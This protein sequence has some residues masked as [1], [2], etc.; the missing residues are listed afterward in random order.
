MEC[1]EKFDIYYWCVIIG[2][3]FGNIYTFLSRKTV[4]N[5]LFEKKIKKNQ[6]DVD[7]SNW[8]W[9]ITNA[10]EKKGWKWSLKTK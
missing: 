5:M 9:Y 6:K 1:L 8:I 2:I 7:I 3:P 4:E 10:T